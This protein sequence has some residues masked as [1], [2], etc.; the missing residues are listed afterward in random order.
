ME[1]IIFN[2][3][4][5]AINTFSFIFFFAVYLAVLSFIL[6]HFA[7]HNLIMPIFQLPSPTDNLPTAKT[8][9]C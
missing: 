2:K 8:L 6:M 5:Y 3:Y 9:T 4:K 1:D 7:A